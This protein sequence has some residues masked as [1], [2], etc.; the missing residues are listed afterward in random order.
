MKK[1]LLIAAIAILAG[2]CSNQPIYN[3]GK[4][5]YPPAAQSLPLDRIEA[6][7]IAGGEQRGWRFERVAPGHLLAVQSQPKYDATVDIKY[8]QTGYEILHRSTRGMKEQNG[9][10]HPHYNFWV[11]NLDSDI[12]TRLSNV[13][14]RQ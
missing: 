10:I 9:T 5:P 4:R 13:P 8:D 3:V 12:Q 11:R 14:L 2:A 1:L 7:I 6:A